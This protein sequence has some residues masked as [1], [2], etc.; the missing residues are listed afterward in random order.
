MNVDYWKG[1]AYEDVIADLIKAQPG[2]DFNGVD[3]EYKVTFDCK[4]VGSVLRG[5]PKT[6]QYRWLEFTNVRGKTGSLLRGAEYFI[7]ETFDYNVFIRKVNL[8][9]LISNKLKS[10]PVTRDEIKACI[11]ANN[12]DQVCYR[13]YTRE[14]RSDSLI[15]ARM[16]D[17]F[18]VADKIVP[19]V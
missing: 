10:A 3:L 6:D 7:I 4:S 9:E 16:L 18:F 5:Y 8:F 11:S 12:I 15:L 19:K 14:G 13:Y 1:K 17:L 2:A